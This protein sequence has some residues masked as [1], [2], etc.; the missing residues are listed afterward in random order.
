MCNVSNSAWGACNSEDKMEKRTLFI[1]W[2]MSMVTLLFSCHASADVAMPATAN[3]EDTKWQLVEVSNESISPLAGEKRPHILLDSSQKKATGF[4]GCNN[5][6]GSYEIDDIALKFG[7]LGS[8]RMS[9]P[10]LQLSLETEVFKA[11]DK[12]SGWE[13]KDDVLF[14]LDGDDI[15][16]RFTKEDNSEIAGT[17]WQWVQTRYNDDRKAVPADPKNY[18]IQFREDSTL[19]V[20]AD[21]NQ[22]G[23][24]YSASA[25]EKRLSIEIT[26]STMAACPEGSLEDEFARAL[27]AAAIYFFKDGD[28]YIDLK[29]DS[30]TIQFSKRQEK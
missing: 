20:K 11:L 22:K 24:T 26:H 18:T 23:G 30:G 19:N 13:I 9:C 6:F 10:D 25:V 28:L 1:G 16:A 4:A 2:A 21:C 7:P 8:T 17:V 5:F 3:I 27:S 12:T 29:Y 15:L 14:F